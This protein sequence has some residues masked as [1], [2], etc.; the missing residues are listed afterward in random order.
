MKCLVSPPDLIVT[1]PQVAPITKLN[2]PDVVETATQ[3]EGVPMFRSG[4]NICH[5][6][7]YMHLFWGENLV[8]PHA[9]AHPATGC[10][11]HWPS[12]LLRL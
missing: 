4:G 6:H 7:L 8:C 3:T 1:H 11:T 9:M 2:E 10:R 12:P 5:R